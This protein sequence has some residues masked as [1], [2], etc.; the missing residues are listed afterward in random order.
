L[1][2]TGEDVVAAIESRWG[3]N[4]VHAILDPVGAATLPSDLALLAPG[5]SILCLATMSGARV[6]L[7]LSLLMKKRA[8]LVG[9]TLRSRSRDEKAAIVRRF[10][11]ELLPG[12]DAGRL[13]VVVDHAFRPADA[14]E[15]FQRMRAN[16]N[17]GKIVIDWRG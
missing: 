6:E 14:S 12:F 16:R 9:S 5:G 3:K 4:A 8:R 11:D 13:A 1:H 17:T 10:R 7:D 2:S 15:A